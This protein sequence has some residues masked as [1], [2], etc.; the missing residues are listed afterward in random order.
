MNSN[1]FTP[2]HPATRQIAALCVF[3]DNGKDGRER[4][5]L[6]GGRHWLD[7]S[8]S[9]AIS[10]IGLASKLVSTFAPLAGLRSV[11]NRVSAFT[12]HH[13]VEPHDLDVTTAQPRRE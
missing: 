8:A 13:R 3:P 6:T 11:F 2:A 7:L 4:A 5:K 12:Q 9:A 1:V 10:R